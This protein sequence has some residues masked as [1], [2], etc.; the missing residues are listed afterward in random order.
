ME[1]PSI[2]SKNKWILGVTTALCVYFIL[3][4]SSKTLNDNVIEDNSNKDVDDK[5]AVW[6][7]ASEQIIKKLHPKI[8]DRAR[9]FINEAEKQGMKVKVTSGLRTYAEQDKLYAQG[10]TKAGG[11]VTN[12]KAGY[13][14]HNFG[15]AFDTVLVENGKINWKSKNWKKLGTLGKT[16]GFE[17]GG[18]WTSFLDQ[19]HFQD[20]FGLTTAQARLKKS[21]NSIDNQGYLLT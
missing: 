18:D 9:A 17:W 10:R 2:N 19:P 4:F 15:N 21:N 20:R 11:K 13:S 14:W 1:V 3:K 8:R 12:A 7:N 16:F 6:D 5:N